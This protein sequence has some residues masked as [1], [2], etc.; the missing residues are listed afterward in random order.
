[1]ETLPTEPHKI[2]EDMSDD[3]PKGYMVADD[4]I[5]QY[6]SE[7]KEA[8]PE[9]LVV[10]KPSESLRA[11]Y[12]TINRVGQEECILDGGSMIVSM[13]RETAVQSGL[14]WDPNIRIN[15]ESASNHVEKTLGLARNVRFAVG[16]LNLFLQVHILDN[17]PYRVLLG[18]PFETLTSAII[19]TKIDGSSEIV[20]TNPNSKE[21]AVVPTYKRG[22][23]PDDLQKQRYQAF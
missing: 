9:D 12:T 5:L 4:P 13:S 6:L 8:E 18:C 11:I 7:H 23:G 14:N 21:V 1:V 10:A 19:K 15:M 2:T 20:L 17:P 16:G 3:I 22:V